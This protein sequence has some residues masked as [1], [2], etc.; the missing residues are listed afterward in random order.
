MAH[1]DYAFLE[2]PIPI[3]G[4][5]LISIAILTAFAFGTLQRNEE[6]RGGDWT[7]WNAAIRE[8][9][10]SIGGHLEIGGEHHQNGNL[11]KAIEEYRIAMNLAAERVRSRPNDFAS[12]DR[13]ASAQI[14]AAYAYL[15]KGDMERAE[16]GYRATLT[17]IP[18]FPPA[19]FRLSQMMLLDGRTA[20]AITLIDGLILSD[21]YG[22]GFQERGKLYVN[23]ALALCMNGF[24]EQAN[25][26]F[27]HA[28]TIEAGLER[29]RCN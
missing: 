17:L 23:K 15:Q 3:R 22:S 29:Y 9:P 4:E 7:L 12:R 2:Q 27:E 26:N 25:L 5:L 8:N 13:L 11:D 6:Y 28:L 24:K 1:S 19:V 21:A 20:E 16:S 18:N 14:N 10:K